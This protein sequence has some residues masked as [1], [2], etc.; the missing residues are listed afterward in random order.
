MEARRI[1]GLEDFE[2]WRARGVWGTGRTGRTG[3]IGEWAVKQVH[4]GEEGHTGVSEKVT[5]QRARAT[6]RGKPRGLA[7]LGF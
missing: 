5:S 2:D 6:G 1:S 7:P 4:L 3:S